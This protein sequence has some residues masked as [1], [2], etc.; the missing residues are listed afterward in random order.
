MAGTRLRMDPEYIPTNVRLPG[1][2]TNIIFAK[3]WT[4]MR[5][6]A[7]AKPEDIGLAHSA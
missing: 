3:F 2:Q 5:V 7:L 6:N 1:R 4:H